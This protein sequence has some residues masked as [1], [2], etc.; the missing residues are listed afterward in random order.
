M[1]GRG[2]F[3]AKYRDFSSGKFISR[4]KEFANREHNFK[5]S[6]PFYEFLNQETTVFECKMEG[7]NGLNNDVLPNV[8]QNIQVEVPFRIEPT[9]FSGAPNDDIHDWFNN[10]ERICIANGFDEAKRLQVLPAFFVDEASRFYSSCEATIIADYSQL[11]QAFVREF[12]GEYDPLILQL[13]WQ[14]RWQSKDE[15]V[16]TFA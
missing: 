16:K 4:E 8:N 2:V 9:K 10:F 7:Q 6:L 5:F 14:D 12:G 11:K 13:R 15:P 3:L 1:P